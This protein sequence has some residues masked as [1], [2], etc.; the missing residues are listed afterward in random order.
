MA[1][2]SK[3]PVILPLSNPTEK[4]EA[5]PKDIYKW[6]GNKALVAT[7]SPFPPIDLKGGK[8]RVGQCNNVFIFPGVGLG[9]LASGAK[10]VLPSFFTAAAKAV[11]DLVPQEDLKQGILMPRVEKLKEVSNSVALA[12]GLVAIRDGVSGPC[13]FSKY[14]HKKDPKR[15]RNLI[16]KMRWEPQYL[17]LV[18]L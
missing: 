2:N 18:P 16:E 6:T 9:T 11:A 17:P 3:R 5:L 13:A 15:L 12:V 4:T 10:E 14:Q 1:A 7:G 8:I